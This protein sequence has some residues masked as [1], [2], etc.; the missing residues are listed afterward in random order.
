MVTITNHLVSQAK[1]SSAGREADGQL[2][3]LT[4]AR[5]ELAAWARRH[6]EHP[7]NACTPIASTGKEGQD[8]VSLVKG[9]S[10]GREQG[11]PGGQREAC[12]SQEAERRFERRLERGRSHEGLLASPAKERPAR[13]P[14]PS[15]SPSTVVRGVSGSSGSP[16]RFLEG[17]SVSP[18]LQKRLDGHIGRQEREARGRRHDPDTT[19]LGPGP[20]RRNMPC[21]SSIQSPARAAQGHMRVTSPAR[22]RGIDFW[23]TKTALQPRLRPTSPPTRQPHG[24]DAA[25]QQQREARAIVTA[26]ASAK[27][28][29]PHL[30][31]AGYTGFPQRKQRARQR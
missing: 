24:S 16:S 27:P 22:E 13:H 11:Y 2:V 28:I 8:A 29:S 15:S 9:S 17:P 18:D 12:R 30:A 14:S 1:E 7:R 20:N 21:A 19:R 25:V 5:D 4:A 3:A 31:A 26:M 10:V 23:N 6:P